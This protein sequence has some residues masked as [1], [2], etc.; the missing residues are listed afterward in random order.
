MGGMREDAERPWTPG[1][2]AAIIADLRRRFPD[3][4]IYPIQRGNLDNEWENIADSARAHDARCQDPRQS[5]VPPNLAALVAAVRRT[6]VSRFYPFTAHEYLC[7]ADGP[8]VWHQ[9]GELAP[10]C[11]GRTRPEG[12]LVYQGQPY[13]HRTLTLTTHVPDE[14]AAEVERLLAGWAWN[15]RV[16]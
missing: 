16:S 14:A 4:H 10:A 3:R 7:F 6:Q 2:R 15:G 9:E 5:W 8:G 12:Y 13:G 11:V 1:Q